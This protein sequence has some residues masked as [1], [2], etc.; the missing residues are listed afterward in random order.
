VPL[1]VNKMLEMKT[2][3]TNI[4]YPTPKSGEE[5]FTCLPPRVMTMLNFTGTL[6]MMSCVYPLCRTS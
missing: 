6:N 5:I 4:F 1:R 3:C 2:A